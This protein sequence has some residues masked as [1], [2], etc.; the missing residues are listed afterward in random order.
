MT[1]GFHTAATAC[2]VLAALGGVLAWLTIRPDVL[3]SDSGDDEPKAGSRGDHHNSCPIS[4][5]PLRHTDELAAVE[6]E[7]RA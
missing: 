7:A 4:G 3:E 5:S 6:G 2:A 1:D